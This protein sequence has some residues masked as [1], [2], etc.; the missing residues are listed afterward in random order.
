MVCQA[1]RDWSS[2][3]RPLPD[4]SPVCRDPD[5]DHVIAAALVVGADHI[6]TGDRDLLVLGRYEDIRMLLARE[7][8]EALSHS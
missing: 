8:I 3:H 7:C 5:D 1:A 6:V 2:D 4:I